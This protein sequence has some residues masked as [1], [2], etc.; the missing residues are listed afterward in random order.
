MKCTS[1]YIVQHSEFQHSEYPCGRCL[2]CRQLRARDWAQRIKYELE[3]KTKMG[4]FVT[5]TFDDQR[6][7]P[8]ERMYLSKPTLQKFIKRVRKDHKVSYYACGEYGEKFGRAHYH[9]LMMRSRTSE[10][11]YTKYWTKGN[12][13]VGSVTE[14]SIA[15]CTGYILKKNPVPVG[16][17]ADA[18]PFHL[19]SRGIGDRFMTGKT[20]I[21]MA[22]EGNIPRRWRALADEKELPDEV[23]IYPKDRV[24]GWEKYGRRKQQ[25][26]FTDGRR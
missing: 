6:S 13:D 4:D 12:V 16:I 9:L 7:D 11:D 8:L 18:V 26:A 22:R 25:Q 15:Y 2:A 23:Y 5:L 19:W 10:I 20:F 24:K 17:P 3:D 14:A 21:E 1:P